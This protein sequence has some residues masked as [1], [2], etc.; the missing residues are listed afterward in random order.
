[1]KR[2]KKNGNELSANRPDR[3]VLGKTV[4]VVVD[5]PLGSVHPERS[6][7]VYG[8]N[9]GY[10]AG[11]TGGDGEEQDAYVFGVDEPIAE[12]DGVVAAIIHRLNDDEDKWVIVPTGYEISEEEIIEKTNF[13]EKYFKTEIIK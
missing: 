10:I 6:N 4:H 7:I 11:V 9:Y 3:T 2:K 12:F 5:R 1:M 8:L 13:Q